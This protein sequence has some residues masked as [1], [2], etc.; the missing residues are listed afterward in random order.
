M[1]EEQSATTGDMS[2][3]IVQAADAARGITAHLGGVA[4]SAATTQ[5]SATSSDD[6]AKRIQAMAQELGQHVS[7]FKV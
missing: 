5:G 1:V 3:S 6:L 2:R 7:K 4:T